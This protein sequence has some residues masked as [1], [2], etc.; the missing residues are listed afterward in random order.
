MPLYNRS[1]LC[2]LTGQD[3]LNSFRPMNFIKAKKFPLVIQ[4]RDRKA[5]ISEQNGIAIKFSMKWPQRLRLNYHKPYDGF[6]FQSFFFC[7]LGVH[8]AAYAGERVDKIG[9]ITG[10]DPG[11]RRHFH[12]FNCF[13]ISRLSSLVYCSCRLV[14]WEHWPCSAIGPNG[15]GSGWQY[16]HGRGGVSI[17]LVLSSGESAIWS[18]NLG[19]CVIVEFPRVCTWLAPTNGPYQSVFSLKLSS[20]LRRIPQEKSFFCRYF[21]QRRFQTTRLC[22]RVSPSGE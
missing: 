3:V 7:S 16:Y 22:F 20:Q 21:C 11:R 13:D 14:L 5:V 8:A 4:R 17:N 2:I 12:V 18:N 1:T 9:R 15:C 19:L 6:W 10:L